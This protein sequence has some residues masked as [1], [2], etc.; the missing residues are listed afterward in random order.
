MQVLLGCV[1]PALSPTAVASHLSSP[2]LRL[3]GLL[4][5]VLWTLLHCCADQVGGLTNEPGH[6]SM[7][8]HYMTVL[9][10]LQ[11]VHAMQAPQMV[12]GLPR[13][14][15]TFMK[16]SISQSGSIPCSFSRR[17]ISCSRSGSRP[18]PAAWPNL[19]SRPQLQSPMSCTCCPAAAKRLP[20]CHV[21]QITVTPNLRIKRTQSAK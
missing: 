5:G 16:A 14:R 3:S 9:E 1:K 13:P 6:T 17:L 21:C 8:P 18:A 19:L 11:G 20:L 12:Q 10:P 7:L 15:R 4:K 2:C